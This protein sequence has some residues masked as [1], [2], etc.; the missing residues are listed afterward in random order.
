MRL[1]ATSVPIDDRRFDTHDGG[2]SATTT[3]VFLIQTAIE[4]CHKSKY[5]ILLRKECRCLRTDSEGVG[6]VR[7]LVWLGKHMGE[8]KLS[9]F[10]GFSESANLCTCH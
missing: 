6:I 7:F 10:S 1:H 9:L 5:T 8:N 3:R 2:T 4:T